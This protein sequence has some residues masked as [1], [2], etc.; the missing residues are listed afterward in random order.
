MYGIFA[1][2]WVIYGVNVGKYSIH[3]WSGIHSG[4]VPLKIAI[5]HS[6]VK[7]PEGRRKARNTTQNQGENQSEEYLN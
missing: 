6:D 4:F 1:D 5:F 2:I 3:R 7:L